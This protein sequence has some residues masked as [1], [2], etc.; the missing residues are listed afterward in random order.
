[1][2]ISEPNKLYFYNDSLLNDYLMELNNRNIYYKYSKVNNY[3]GI[4]DI[5]YYDELTYDDPI[6]HNG[7]DDRYQFECA[8][9]IVE[10]LKGFVSYYHRR[11]FNELIPGYKI[12]KFINNHINQSYLPF[13]AFIPVTILNPNNPFDPE[14]DSIFVMNNHSMLNNNFKTYHCYS[15]RTRRIEFESYPI[16]SLNYGVTSYN[17]I[18]LSNGLNR[19]IYYIPDTNEYY[20][21]NDKLKPIKL[22]KLRELLINHFN[23]SNI[24]DGYMDILNY[25]WDCNLCNL[26]KLKDILNSHNLISLSNNSF[27]LDLI[28]Y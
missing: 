12:R 14:R 8:M 17:S 23:L 10:D 13:K 4:F 7:Y 25:D 21:I 2:M 1:M 27:N 3:H 28:E 19:S 11:I 18:I 5:E 15:Q 6:W 9:P 22:Y 20:F 26:E 16:E 24:M